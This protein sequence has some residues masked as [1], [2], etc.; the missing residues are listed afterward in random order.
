MAVKRTGQRWLI[1]PVVLAFMAGAGLWAFRK[2]GRWLVAPDPLQHAWAIVV[3]S[4]R[5]PFRAMEAAEIYRQG[6]APEVWLLEDEPD[7]A[8]AEFARLGIRYPTELEY[9]QQVLK[10]LGVPKSAIRVLE[11][12]TSN[13]VSEAKLIA[14]ELRRQG[15]ATV[16]LVTSAVHTRRAKTIWHITVGDHLQAI[17]RYDPSEPGDLE[18]WWRSTQD[19]QVVEHEVLGLINAWLGFAVGPRRE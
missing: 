3:L 19:I 1:L 2:V 13:T 6:W 8:D 17:V 18:H 12:P 10:R 16:I 11:P 4:G 5:A 9:N 15:G 7:K 14:G